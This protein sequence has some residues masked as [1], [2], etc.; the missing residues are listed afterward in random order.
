MFYKYFICSQIRK[1]KKLYLNVQIQ[2]FPE[3]TKLD[4]VCPLS[5]S[6]LP[7]WQ[8]VPAQNCARHMG[9]PLCCSYPRLDSAP[10]VCLLCLSNCLC[11][12]HLVSLSILL[13]C[14]LATHI[15]RRAFL[16]HLA[17]PDPSNSSLDPRQLLYFAYFCS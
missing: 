9:S 13:F 8:D 5:S 7:Q 12:T 15:Y 10:Q 2:I 17:R 16:D 11:R 3:M 1:G 14:H 6:V 4:N